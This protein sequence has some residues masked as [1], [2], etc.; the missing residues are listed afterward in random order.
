MLK[1]KTEEEAVRQDV[2][3][4]VD[5]AQVKYAAQVGVVNFTPSFNEEAATGRHVKGLYNR[6]PKVGRNGRGYPC[7]FE[8]F[9]YNWDLVMLQPVIFEA[10]PRRARDA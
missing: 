5:S 7:L 1:R 3:P 2:V 10:K 8:G 6:R 9:A 4:L